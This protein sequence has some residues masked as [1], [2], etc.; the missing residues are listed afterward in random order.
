MII[1][2]RVVVTMDGPPIENGAVA[3]SGDR[4]TDV[5]KF[6][7]ISKRNSDREVVDV[8][9]QALLP[10]LI[11]AHSHLDYTCL[12]GKIPRQESFTDWIRAINAEKA[13]LS[14]EDYVVSINQGFAEAKLFG[15][16][17]IA[18]LTA[19]PELISQIQTPIRTWWFAELI[20]V[21][22]PSRANEIADLAVETVK[23]AE[24]WGLAPHAPFTASGNLYRR[25][26]EMARSEDVLLTTHLAESREE[27]TM[28]RDS[29]GPLYRFMQE[30]GRSMDDCGEKTPVALFSEIVRDSSTPLGMT[31]NW[32]VVHL[33]ELV[34]NDLDLMERS[35]S[36]F[37]IVHC[38][39]TH[40]YFGHSP[41]QFHKLRELGFNI[42]LGTDS[43]ASN[44]DLSL[45]AEMRAFQKTFPDVSPEEIL[46][47]VTING[48]RA[49]R[50]EN[51]LG[52]LRPGF[53]ADLIAIPIARP[54]SAFEEI[55]GFDQ[56]VN[57]SMIGGQI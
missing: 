41:F 35:A 52:K 24:H 26:E 50:Q 45:L 49:L 7:D 33:N 16:T 43:L 17:T 38:P 31:E 15:T 14:P 42:C 9:E 4:I 39:R 51:V 56:S 5:G 11:N 44:D 8:D 55:I 23:S 12:R 25:C 13:E 30:I 54:T 3:I 57:W 10:G 18:N 53:L 34:D 37:S 22:D 2:A 21:R 27:M 29:S 47:M 40:E 48:A 1:R 32:I 46:K 6:S 36:K 28:F 19:F 20:D